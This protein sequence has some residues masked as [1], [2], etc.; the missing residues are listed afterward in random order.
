MV[1]TGGATAANRQGET[2]WPEHAEFCATEDREAALLAAVDEPDLTAD[3]LTKLFLVPPL[4]R[5]TALSTWGTVYTAMYDSDRLT[6][7]LRWPDDSW[8]L[9]LQEFSVG[10]RRRKLSMAVPAPSDA[11]PLPSVARSRPLLIA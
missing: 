8:S 10:S 9:D 6:L 3:L 5:P 4:Y 7:D 1:V 2:E 11:P